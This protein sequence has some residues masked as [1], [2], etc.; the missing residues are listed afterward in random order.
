[1][2]RESI[3]EV[4]E[5]I[6]T[7]LELKGENHFKTRAYRN[8]AEIVSSYAGDFVQLAK[9]DGLEE[10]KGIGAALAQKIHELVS[11]GKLEYYELIAFGV[12]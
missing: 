9:D 6:A 11:T 3:A 5:N 2:T 1:M 7:L 12:S 10:I 4:L 8:G